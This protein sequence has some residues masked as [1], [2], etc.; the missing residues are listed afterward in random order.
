MSNNKKDK[1]TENL[2]FIK[3]VINEQKISVS[4]IETL[5]NIDHPLFS[6]K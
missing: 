2:Q 1:Q 5:S 4:E 3:K 6:F